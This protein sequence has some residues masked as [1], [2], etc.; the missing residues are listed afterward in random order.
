MKM[1]TAA[2]PMKK[3]PHECSMPAYPAPHALPLD[4][5][6]SLPSQLYLLQKCRAVANS[7]RINIKELGAVGSIVSRTCSAQR[8]EASLACTDSCRVD[9]CIEVVF[10]CC[11]RGK[12]AK[13]FCA[14]RHKPRPRTLVTYSIFSGRYVVR[15]RSTDSEGGNSGKTIR[16][17]C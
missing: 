6:C 11:N 13:P 7:R 2:G 1:S 4:G 17:R 9:T 8:V 5:A 3:W 16:S 15:N 12:I 14:M 10:D